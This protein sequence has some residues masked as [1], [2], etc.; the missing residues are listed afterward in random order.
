MSGVATSRHRNVAVSWR[1]WVEPALLALT[2]G[3]L[4]AGGVAWVAGGGRWDEVLWAAATVV[5]VVPSAVWVVAGL[6]RRD[7]GVASPQRV[8]AEAR[9]QCADELAVRDRPAEAAELRWSL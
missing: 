3:L 8:R 5:A 6:L 9:G 2:S 1:R 4:S 7:L